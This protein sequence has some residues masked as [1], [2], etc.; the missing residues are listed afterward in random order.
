MNVL[1]RCD[2]SPDIGLGHIIRCLALA[3]ELHEVH[4]CRIIFAMRTGSLGIQMAEGKGYKVL[5]SEETDRSFDY[6]KWFNECVRNVGAK[7]IILDVRDELPRKVLDELRNEGILIII[8]DDP[9]DKRL[10]ADLAFYPPVPQ[11][12]RIDWTG[13]TGKLYV[14]WEWVILRKEFSQNTNIRGNKLAFKIQNS[15]F[16]ILV[17][18]GGSDPQGM[19]LKALKALEM[20]ED[21]FEVVVVLGAGFQHKDELNNLLSDYKHHFE[22]QENV[23][24]MAELMA[25]SDLAVASFGV[26]AYELAVMGVPAIYTCLTEDHAESASAFVGEGMGIS[27][28]VSGCVRIKTLAGKVSCLLK[29]KPKRLRMSTVQK[30]NGGGAER[31]ADL[32]AKKLE[33]VQNQTEM[34]F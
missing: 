23:K 31:I 19:T 28:G 6:K 7:A 29:N 24:N 16:K 2:G 4:N 26:T 30:I 22:V 25:Q 3:D 33:S 14:G 5:T 20:L 1:I 21:D 27:L 17:T 15:K 10:S 18:M 13:F 8:I 11:V 12:K 32:I 9:E 34:A